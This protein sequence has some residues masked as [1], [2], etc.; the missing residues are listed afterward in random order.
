MMMIKGF[1]KLF[2]LAAIIPTLSLAWLPHRARNPR[3]L[4]PRSMHHTTIL[5]A[6]KSGGGGGGGNDGP[7]RQKKK[8]AGVQVKPL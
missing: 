7:Q 3:V 1:A 4:V 5:L 8:G 2:L 6:E